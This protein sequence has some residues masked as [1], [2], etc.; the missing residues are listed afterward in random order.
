MPLRFY[1]AARCC[2]RL[3]L[4][5][6]LCLAESVASA[7]VAAAASLR[8]PRQ[9]PGKPVRRRLPQY[10]GAFQHATPSPGPGCGARC[11]RAR[12]RST[13]NS[14][15]C[16][17][18]CARSA[19]CRRRVPVA[20]AGHAQKRLPDICAFWLCRYEETACAG[21][22]FSRLFSTVPQARA[23]LPK[24]FARGVCAAGLLGASPA[25]HGLPERCLAARR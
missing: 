4:A 6:D 13:C 8:L 5:C 2:V 22:A 16:H 9:L 3:V 12:S 15:V 24:L 10:S 7:V 14:D 23:P 25:A 17:P 21:Q 19:R 1:R 20:R 11:G 18:R